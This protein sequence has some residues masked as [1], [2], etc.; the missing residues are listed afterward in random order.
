M[1]S[2]KGQI[3]FAVIAGLI[4]LIAVVIFFTL[5]TGIIVPPI[6]PDVRTVQNSMENFIRGAAQETLKN[7]ST[8]GG[9]LEPG[10]FSVTYLG[11]SVPFW[12]LNG[13][14]SIPDV[15]SNLV[16]GVTD[17]LADN[18]EGFAASFEGKNVTV[19]DPQ[20]TMNILTN[21]IDFTV[22]MPTTVNGVPV[23]QPYRVT[24]PT[25]FGEQYEF[26]KSFV[27]FV[28]I[29]RPFEYFI[30]N[31]MVISEYDGLVQKVPTYIHLTHCG[32]FVF[33]TWWDIKP[34]MEY[35]IKSVLAHTYMPGKVPLNIMHET[36]YPKWPIPSLD[37]KEY[38][39]VNI[40]F[41]LPDDFE[42]MHDNFQLSPDPIMVFA[43]P[44]PL[45]GICQSG[46]V[47][48]DYYLSFPVLVRVN[49]P[50]TG[51]T[52]QFAI[53]V[54]VLDNKPGSW[55][56][57][58]GYEPDIQTQICQAQ[59]CSIKIMV[60]DSN[61]DP[62]PYAAVNFMGCNLGRTS[63]G[64]VLETIAPCGLGPLE[65]YKEHYATYDEMKTSD[66]VG[67]VTVTLKKIPY[68]N[69]H[70]YE[71]NVFNNTAI[72]K[73]QI[74]AD[75]IN[76]IDS[77]EARPEAAHITFFKSPEGKSYER[78]FDSRGGVIRTIPPANYY[79]A[80]MLLNSETFATSYGA[81]ATEFTLRE[82][83][84]GHDLYIY[85]PYIFGF[86]SLD[87]NASLK[88]TVRMT[89]LLKGCGIGPISEAEIDGEAVL[90]C[91]RG[92]DPSTGELI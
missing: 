86:S 85:I 5:Q 91:S 13:Q 43:E 1:Q 19:G 58:S 80:G 87:T 26:S 46:P 8:Y 18:K 81:F 33:K 37:G 78:I 2:R 52:F 42:L 51:N 57:V 24:I 38:H 15:P 72:N 17:Y 28:N 66:E 76:P 83:M 10:F 64:G 73:Y 27:N 31:S 67:N 89:E 61:R 62:V 84:D 14:I 90:P 75:S 82:D 74:L 48:V 4:I 39:D 21:Q 60:E 35:L 11:E 47:Y 25:K 22:N 30:I 70:L 3:E 56:D 59:E 54:Y 20:V 68:V 77:F 9:Y 69:I 88:T 34:E 16:Q 41:D 7:M 6:S 71:V 53:H 23:Q 36:N 63:L 79:V 92:Y 45:V 40:T 44:I 29:N 49:D 50:L 32:D 55:V 12:H 65:V